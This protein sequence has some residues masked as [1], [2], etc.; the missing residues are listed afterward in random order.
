MYCDLNNAY[1]TVSAALSSHEQPN[2]VSDNILKDNPNNQIHPNNLF[3]AQGD[4]QVCHTNSTN[5]AT[6]C[7]RLNGEPIIPDVEHMAT[8][9]QNIATNTKMP[10][11]N[12]LYRNVQKLRNKG[13]KIITKDV[14]DGVIVSIIGILILFLLDI[15]TRVSRRL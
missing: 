7:T 11:Q 15:L 2:Y 5:P 12:K 9:I 6:G 13:A 3:T 14:R 10:R 8:D 1:Q 4:F